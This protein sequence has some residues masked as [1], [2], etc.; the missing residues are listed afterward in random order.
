MAFQWSDNAVHIQQ[1]YRPWHPDDGY[2]EAAV[3]AAETRLDL[4]FPASLRLFYRAWGARDDLT[5]TNQVL[6]LL[7]HVFVQSDALVICAENQAVWYWA[8]PCDALGQ[9]DPPVVTAWNGE[10]ALVW[11]PS[12]PQLSNF[13]D[14]LTYMHAF[15]GGAIHGGYSHEPVTDELWQRMCD[16]GDIRL[17]PTVPP[18]VV[19]DAASQPWSLIIGE[20]YAMHGVGFVGVA[21]ENSARLEEISQALQ[22]TWQYQW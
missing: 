14:Y 12:H 17:L 8:I 1:L 9:D 6:L 21:A 16:Y 19:P 18:W 2:A 3:S 20:R 11:R 10:P 7:E 22:I 13:L 15:D 4:R 5:R